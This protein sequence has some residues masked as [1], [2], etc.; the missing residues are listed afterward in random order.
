M[1]TL[2]HF[3]FSLHL[4]TP[5]LSPV[6]QRVRYNKNGYVSVIVNNDKDTSILVVVLDLRDKLPLTC[7]CSCPSL[8]FLSSRPFSLH[9]PSIHTQLVSHVCV[10]VLQVALT[11]ERTHAHDHEHRDMEMHEE[12]EGRVSGDDHDSEALPA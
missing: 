3:P 11:V 9:S 8:F 10:P 2:D 12:G 1:A 5:N 6:Q 7:M 4:F